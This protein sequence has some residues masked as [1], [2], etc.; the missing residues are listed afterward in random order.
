MKKYLYY[1][2]FIY[3]LTTSCIHEN[4]SD[5]LNKNI[6]P[7]NEF[8]QIIKQSWLVNA[9]IANNKKSTLIPKDSINDV[10]IKI[11]NDYSY[12]EE[13]LSRS[14][15]FYA[16]NPLLLDSLIKDIIDSLNTL[17]H[18]NS[19]KDETIIQDTLFKVLQNYPPLKDYKWNENYIFTTDMKD[20]ILLFFKTHPEK[21]ENFTLENIIEKVNQL[22]KPKK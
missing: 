3:L 4:I 16:A 1:Y 10:T 19:K 18:A 13:D 6:I 5:S 12:N 14:I 22:S 21:L 11:L 2:L 7:S 20:S 15:K 9:H 8:Q 17:H